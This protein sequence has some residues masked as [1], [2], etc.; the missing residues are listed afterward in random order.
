MKILSPSLK[1]LPLDIVGSTKFGRY[2]KISIEQT[3]NMIVSDDWLVPFAGYQVVDT[4]APNGQ[5]R[6]LYSSAQYKHLIMVID[7]GVY[8]VNQNLG[9]TKIAEIATFSGDVF[10]D[11]NNAGQIAI[12]DK[13]KIYIFDYNND[14]FQAAN[15]NFLPGYVAFQDTY[16]IAPDLRTSQWRLSDNNNGLSWPNDSQHIGQFQTKPDRPVAAVRFPG[17]GN[18]LF[19]FGSTVTE[20]WYDLGYQLFPYQKNTYFNIDYGCLNPA[21]IASND[22]II[23]WLGANE[24]SGPV[25]MV[26]DGGEPKQISNDGINFRFAQLKN[27]TNSYGFLFKQDGHNI[28]QITFPSDNFS[29]CYDFNTS[30]FF[31]LTDEK[32][33]YHIAKRVV[34]FNNSYY[35]VSFNDGNLYELNT[36]YTS[37]NGQEIPR[38]RVCKNIRMPDTS[39]FVVNELSFT[40]EQ[41]QS[42]D[43]QRVDLSLS[44]NGGESFG[45]SLGKTLNTVG[46]RPNRLRY[47]NLGAAN[48][49]VLQFRFWGEGRFV[50]TDGVVSYYQ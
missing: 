21:T 35:F 16:F 28:Y 44:K 20:A 46:H 18:M 7:N 4:I 25:I 32:M 10:I 45:S 26:S 34:Y 1:T 39:R 22:N 30:Q 43:V 11:E 17:K 33:N 14:T 24:K 31:T 50:A 36:K 19:V 41:G 5:G 38:V 37:Y 48:D 9:A 15:L 47:W 42:N 13:S 3:F 40:I 12:C 23:V 2:P 49:L 29:L 8:K 27:P 6:G